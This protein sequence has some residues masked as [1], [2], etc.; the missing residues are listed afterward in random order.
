MSEKN[1]A[2][3]ELRDIIEQKGGT[4]YFQ[5]EGYQHGAWIISLEGKQAIA[6]AKGN[7]SI[8]QLDRLYVPKVNDPK[9]WSDYSNDLIPNA[10]KELLTLLR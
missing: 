7:K 10:D 8:P 1:R 6:E 3:G 2:Y 9:T 4:M 5:R